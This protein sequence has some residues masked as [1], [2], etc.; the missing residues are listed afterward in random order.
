MTL[1]TVGRGI[2]GPGWLINPADAL[3]GV[4]GLPQSAT[5]QTVLLTGQNAAAICG[6]HISGFPTSTLKRLLKE[7]NIFKRINESGL[8]AAFAN[9]YT[10]QYLNGLSEGRSKMSATTIAALAGNCSLLRVTD[11]LKG[12]GVYQDITNLLLEEP[13]YVI[14]RLEPE[15]AANN[16]VQLALKNDFTLFEYFQT[17]RCGHHQQ[18]APAVRILNELDRFIAALIKRIAGTSLELL[19][20]SDHGNIEDLSL[21]THTFNPI[22]VIYFGAKKEKFQKT[23]SLL[24]IFPNI[25]NYLG[26]TTF[27]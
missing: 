6:R 3:L 20:V 21:R 4:S 16:L 19:I 17:D 12:E 22:P 7:D 25:L 14:P 1:S 5:G 26:L 23:S 8:K 24:H 15:C 27:Y 13:G 9:V 18:M 2:A 11:L 10:R